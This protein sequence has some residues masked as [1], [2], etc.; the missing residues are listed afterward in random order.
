M[1]FLTVCIFLL[2]TYGL[3]SAQAMPLPRAK[4]LSS[5]MGDPPRL[6]PMTPVLPST[7]SKHGHRI[8]HCASRRSRGLRL[9]RL[10]TGQVNAGPLTSCG[11]TGLL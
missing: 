8:A 3:A 2:A 5:G 7:T 6:A 4:P 9:N 11:S 10:S 1:Q